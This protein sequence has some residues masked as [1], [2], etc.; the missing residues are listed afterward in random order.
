[1]QYVVKLLPVISSIETYNYELENYLTLKLTP[2]IPNEFT[3]NDTFD[4]PS[5][6]SRLLVCH[7]DRG[8]GGVFYEM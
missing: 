1:M 2:Y 4:N 3:I 8:G 6:G 5:Q 7:A